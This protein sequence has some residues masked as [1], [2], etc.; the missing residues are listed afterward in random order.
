MEEFYNHLQA[1]GRAIQIHELQN[2]NEM[3]CTLEEQE[4]DFEFCLEEIHISSKYLIH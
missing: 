4:E 3:G 1:Q 2:M